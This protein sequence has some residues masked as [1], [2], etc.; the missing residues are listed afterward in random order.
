MEENV[1]VFFLNT[2]YS[3]CREIP[4][5]VVAACESQFQSWKV[6]CSQNGLSSGK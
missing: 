1:S 2:V 3:D 6:S 4:R 5:I